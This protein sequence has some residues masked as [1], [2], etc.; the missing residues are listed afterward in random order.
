MTHSGGVQSRRRVWAAR[1]GESGERDTVHESER[2]AK[3]GTMG[4]I[5]QEKKG[6]D[7]LTYKKQRKGKR[8]RE[9]G[10]G[11]L[12]GALKLFADQ[13]PKFRDRREH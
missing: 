12:N 9:R 2:R 11:F 6:R 7:R 10:E 13:L 4:G 5:Y 8:E 3:G 1:P